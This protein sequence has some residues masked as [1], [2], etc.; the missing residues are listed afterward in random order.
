MEIGDIDQLRNTLIGRGLT[1][2]QVSR[3]IY[4]LKKDGILDVMHQVSKK[5]ETI[6]EALGVVRDISE[7]RSTALE[8]EYRI[9]SILDSVIE[10][11]ISLAN[12]RGYMR[13]FLRRK[14]KG[15]L[16]TKM[17]T[18]IDEEL[19]IFSEHL[20]EEFR[21]FLKSLQEAEGD[22]GIS[23]EDIA[24]LEDLID[25]REIILNLVS[26]R[27]AKIQEKL[28]SKTT[29][30]F[31]VGVK[32]R[33]EAEFVVTEEF[34]DSFLTA[35]GEIEDVGRKLEARGVSYIKLNE[36]RRA[37]RPLAERIAS[38][39][40]SNVGVRLDSLL[41][42][43]SNAKEEGNALLRITDEIMEIKADFERLRTETISSIP[44]ELEELV[45]VV[46]ILGI[47]FPRFPIIVYCE[48]D[49]SSLEY[50]VSL[51]RDA[52]DTL[53]NIVEE[54]KL[55]TPYAR[56]PEHKFV[57]DTETKFLENLL[58]LLRTMRLSKDL[59]LEAYSFT[60]LIEEVLD[61]YPKWRS[62]VIEELEA[63]GSLPIDE[64]SFI[65]EAWRD[66]FIRNLEEEGMVKV[67]DG[68]LIASTHAVPE[69][70]RLEMKLEFLEDT[71]EEIGSISSIPL[72]RSE[73]EQLRDKLDL[74]KDLLNE[75]NEEEAL[76][77]MRDVDEGL[78][79]L[80]SS[81]GGAKIEKDED[82]RP[83]TT[84]GWKVDPNS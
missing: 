79:R 11:L 73:I 60:G 44:K 40:N 62:Y 47:S 26:K 66:W 27:K 9:K 23:A 24:S 31:V 33:K 83:R 82:S 28:E 59:P 13:S 30:T 8:I 74:A 57:F 10:G 2:Q 78:R 21:K 42:F 4:L 17:L 25:N 55:F 35:I 32:R 68:R 16:L 53:R 52:R 37:A 51:M 43:L 63:K 58:D 64:L 54:L 34:L 15:N 36:L 75:G 14:S 41:D 38:V 72:D 1:P 80:L 19:D 7:I 18:S 20:A 76:K 71:Y 67:E 69:I 48:E 70:K 81:L 5:I 39:V 46:R 29:T 56:V 49:I 84:S 45:D 65:P 3:L 61:L 77:L 22:V 50:Q 6:R 12:D